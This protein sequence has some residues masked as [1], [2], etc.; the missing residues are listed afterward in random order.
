MTNFENFE[1]GIV[2]ILL[3]FLG[4]QNVNG[5]RSRQNMWIGFYYEN[6]GK[7]YNV[8]LGNIKKQTAS[9]MSV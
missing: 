2:L 1:I 7:E 8:F 5:Y 9:A 4:L 6:G 3:Q